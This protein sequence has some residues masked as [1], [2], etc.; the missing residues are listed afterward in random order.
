MAYISR[1]PFAREEIHR[2]R[3]FTNHTCDWCGNFKNAKD[4]SRF[5]YEYRTE[6]D[7]GR[8][9]EHEGQFCSK[10]CHD[11]YHGA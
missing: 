5:L 7:G 1:D 3:V 9:F 6:M 10:G 8:K 4:G 11:T 2:S